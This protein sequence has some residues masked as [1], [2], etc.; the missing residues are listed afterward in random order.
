M[1]RILKIK[2]YTDAKVQ[3]A[4]KDDEMFKTIKEGKKEGDHQK[5]KAFGDVFSDDEIKALV[6]YVRSLK[7]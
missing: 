1:G 3:A 7:K 4:M 6:K 2:D 5:M